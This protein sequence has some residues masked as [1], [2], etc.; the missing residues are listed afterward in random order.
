MSESDCRRVAVV[1]PGGVGCFFAAH[2]ADIGHDVLAC[3]RRPFD[4]YVVESDVAPV[5]GPA[6]VVVDPRSLPWRGPADWVLVGLKTHQTADAA[7]WFEPLC[8]P[9]TV[10]VALQN[11]VDAVARLD[12]L[13]AGA[14]V[15]PTVV[16]CGG[17][18]LA[19]GHV[20]N[21]MGGR[22]IVPDG[23]SAQGLIELCAGSA[24]VIEPSTSYDVAAWVKL[25]LNVVAN[26]LTALTGKPL[27]VLGDPAI[28][29][30]ARALL[31][32]CWTVGAAI[33]VPLELDGIEDTIAAMAAMA[34]GSTSMAQ[35]VRAGR[36][37]EYDALHGAVI[38]TGRGAGVATPVH[39]VV[40]GLLA[41]R[42]RPPN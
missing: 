17:E 31:R 3:A 24:I 10:V 21:T 37:T 5:E 6:T 38:R 29:P 39:E 36:P 22:L 20:L 7:A 15:L 9:D 25:G 40:Y 18:V 27:G 4:R 19:A 35:D 34:E 42:E 33:G 41:A 16:Y 1:G 30:V 2:L 28:E 8:G 23:P 11:G 32:E 12:P 13:V 26:G 14:E